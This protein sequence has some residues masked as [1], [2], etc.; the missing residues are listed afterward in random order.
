MQLK[1]GR[2]IRENRGLFSGMTRM[3]RT[4][5]MDMIMGTIYDVLEL[6]LT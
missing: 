5:T 1:A 6:Y 4:F 3:Q 2:K